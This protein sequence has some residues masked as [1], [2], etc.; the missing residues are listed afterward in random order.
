MTLVELLVVMAIMAILVAFSIPALKPMLESQRAVSGAKI[1]ALKLQQTRLKAMRENRSCGI[2]FMRFNDNNAINA[3]LQMRTVKN[4]PNFTQL[5]FHGYDVRC[6]VTPNKVDPS[7]P[8]SENDNT[9]TIELVIKFSTDKTWTKINTVSPNDIEKYFIDTWKRKVTGGLKIQFNRQGKWYKLIDSFT[10]DDCNVQLPP[11]NG[12]SIFD[13]V[14]FKVA[15][16][17]I[18]MLNSITVLPRGTIVD[19]QYSGRENRMRRDSNDNTPTI[20]PKYFNFISSE[21]NAPRS[22]VIMFSP[23]GYVDRF[24]VDGEKTLGDDLPFRGVFYFL[25]GEWDRIDSGEDGKNNLATPSNFWVTVKERDGTVRMSPNAEIKNS[26]N[27]TAQQ[28]AYEDLYK[29]VGG[30]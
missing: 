19:L 9:A 3:S 23:A 10:V 22:V 27:I 13:A 2:E 30:I 18:P 26:N 25:V 14:E 8:D 4:A 20:T 6:L 7:D 21:N 15:Q 28:H 1:V 11:N 17:P 29:N 12:T 24:Y 5:N 16:R